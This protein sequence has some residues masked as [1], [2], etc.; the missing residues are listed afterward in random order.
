MADQ[1]KIDYDKLEQAASRFEN[2]SQTVEQML[3]KVRAS[4]DDLKDGWVG[5]GSDAF[6]SEMEGEL[7]P[8]VQRL[9]EVLS[10]SRVVSRD[11][12]NLF[13]QAEDEASSRFRS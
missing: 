8:A 11:I 10:E 1:V 6:F 3:Q 13:E 5:R 9:Q 2:L 7:L 4:M 12:G